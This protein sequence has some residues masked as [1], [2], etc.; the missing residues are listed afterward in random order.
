M[1]SLLSG[2]KSNNSTGGGVAQICLGWD[3]SACKAHEGSAFS[4]TETDK[5]CKHNPFTEQTIREFVEHAD[6]EV[7]AALARAHALYHSSWSKGGL[8]PRVAV[9]DKLSTLL[10]DNRAKLAQTMALEMGKPVARG[11]MPRRGIGGEGGEAARVRAEQHLGNPVELERL[12][13]RERQRCVCG[14]GRYT[15]STGA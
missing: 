8:A 3:T 6:A 4:K 15:A 12:A 11:Q 1:R 13:E 14:A 2:Q 7:E 9:L 5:I 10:S